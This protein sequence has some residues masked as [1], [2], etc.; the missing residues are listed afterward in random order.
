MV[1][2]FIT[3]FCGLLF[4]RTSWVFDDTFL[5]DSWILG[6]NEEI[7]VFGDGKKLSK[8]KDID[9][10]RFKTIELKVKIQNMTKK[11][12]EVICSLELM[13]IH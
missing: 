11:R 10:S 1:T 6:I 5:F 13:T 3:I 7:I 9:I 2:L 4:G 12:L 8:K